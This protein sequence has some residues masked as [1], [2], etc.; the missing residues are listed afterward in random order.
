MAVRSSGVRVAAQPGVISTYA[1]SV[2]FVLALLVGCLA[3]LAT[4]RGSA[5]ASAGPLPDAGIGDAAGVYKVS[6]SSEAPPDAFHTLSPCNIQVTQGTTFTLDLLVNAGTNQVVAQ[7]AYLTFTNSLLQVV[8]PGGTCAN[9]ATTVQP[10]TSSFEATLQNTV[11]NA[12][13]EIA[14]ASGTFGAARTGQ[15]RVAR[16]HFC[17]V[18]SGTATLN[19]QFSPPAPPQRN[20]GITDGASTRVENRALYQNCNVTVGQLC[21]VN[22]D[23]F[24][25][26]TTG[27]IIPGTTRVPGSGCNA[28]A[29]PITLPFPYEFY[30]T[31]YTPPIKACCSSHQATPPA[32]TPACPTQGSTTR[33][34]PTGTTSTPSL[35]T[36][37]ASIR[38][39]RALLPTAYSQS[40]GGRGLWLTTPGPTLR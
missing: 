18:N 11:N 17:A 30:G 1:A 19:W 34:S 31:T 15:F 26:T 4:P 20:T 37:W 24:V 2:L 33:Y 38:P 10:D 7:Q 40:S 23:Y 3:L 36:L 16:V 29:V 8:A 35:M 27:T 13:G 6:Q 9:P 25:M 22:P 39:P 28:C 5:L 32:R 12:T 14:Y 21:T